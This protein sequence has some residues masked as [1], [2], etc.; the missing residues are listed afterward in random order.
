[1]FKTIKTPDDIQ[2][3]RQSARVEARITEL[4]RLLTESDFKVLLDYDQPNEGIRAQRQ[5]WR[6]EIRQLEGET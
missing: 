5:E 2:V 4:K 6:K 1:M 3:E